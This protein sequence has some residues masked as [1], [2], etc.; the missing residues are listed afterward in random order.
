MPGPQLYSNLV[1]LI[2][3]FDCIDLSVIKQDCGGGER[4]MIMGGEAFIA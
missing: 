1:G 4:G 3:P 2:K